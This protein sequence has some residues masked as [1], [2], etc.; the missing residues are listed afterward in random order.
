MPRSHQNNSIAYAM[1]KKKRILYSSLISC[2]FI[3]IVFLWIFAEI[4]GLSEAVAKPAVLFGL[5]TLGGG[6]ERGAILLLVAFLGTVAGTILIWFLTWWLT[7]LG[8]SS[9]KA[10]AAKAKTAS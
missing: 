3:P 9:R 2:V 4:G 6:P 8:H 5:I 10:K 1:Q 7:G